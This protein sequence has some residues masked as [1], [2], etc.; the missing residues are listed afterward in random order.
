MFRVIEVKKGKQ[1][2]Y[3]TEYDEEAVTRYFEMLDTNKWLKFNAMT[4]EQYN[5]AIGFEELVYSI[6]KE[7]AVPEKQY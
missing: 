6:L 1:T 3:L 2:E 4:I 7:L 5:R